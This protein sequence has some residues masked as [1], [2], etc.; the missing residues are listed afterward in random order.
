[1]RL[2]AG[3]V[4][5]LAIYAIVLGIVARVA[6]W[7]WQV[8]GLDDVGS[9][10]GLHDAGIETLAVAP[11]VLALIGVGALRGIAVFVTAYL[12]GAA[13]TAPFVLARFA[14]M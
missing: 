8:H 5:R 11:I 10:Q 4:V 12:I 14:G 6:D 9:L 7:Q 13:F 1:V 2:I 3:F